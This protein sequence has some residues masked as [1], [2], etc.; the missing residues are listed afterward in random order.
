MDILIKVIHT[1]GQSKSVPMD[2]EMLLRDART[3]LVGKKMMGKDDIFLFK[4]SEVDRDS[5]SAVKLG[6]ILEDNSVIRIGA[7]EKP[8]PGTESGVDIYRALNKGQRKAIFENIQLFRGLTFKENDGFVKTFNDLFSW[9]GDYEPA[10]NFPRV[11][12]SIVSSYAFSKV[13]SEL[14]MMETTTTSVS[15]S[16]PYVNAESEFKYEKSKT[17]TQ[18]D[19]KE[20]LSSRFV[21]RKVSF[22]IN[23]NRLAANETFVKAVETAVMSDISNRAKCT[24]LLEVLNEWGYYIP[25]EFSLGGALYSTEETTISEFSQA[26][27]EKKEFSASFKGEVEKIGGGAAYNQASGSSQTTTTSTKYKNINLRQTGGVAGLTNDYAKWVESLRKA[28]QWDIVAIERMH[29][30]LMLLTCST[31]AARGNSIL[32]AC[33]RLLNENRSIQAIAQIQPYVDIASYTNVIEVLI[34]PWA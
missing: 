7:A 5:E 28:G 29:P 1:D 22:K 15:L 27:E 32:S 10:V 20:Y 8:Q 31:D 33:L 17:T 30:S 14:K 3:F 25:L 18:S 24:K 11:N 13:T 2:S 26:E 6:L 12:T 16:S 4:G 21:V 23:E 19:V 9:K 34:N